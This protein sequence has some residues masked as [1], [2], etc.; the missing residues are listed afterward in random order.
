MPSQAA[1]HPGGGDG[2]GGNGDGATLASAATASWREAWAERWRAGPPV[3]VRGDL[4][5]LC[6]Q[7]LGTTIQFM[8]MP[9]MLAE[10]CGFSGALLREQLL[11]GVGTWLG[12]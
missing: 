5:G 12:V 9:A 10:S 3:F 6:G 2:D 8:L 4:E 1:R 11:P 7:L